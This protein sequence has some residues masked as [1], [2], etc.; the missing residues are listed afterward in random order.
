MTHRENLILEMEN[1]NRILCK[2]L[3]RISTEELDD[4]ARL[5]LNDGCGSV[6]YALQ[7]YFGDDPQW[8][9]TIL[10]PND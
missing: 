8:D 6:L 3:V 1:L 2:Y 7:W 9:I 10:T 5:E 4:T